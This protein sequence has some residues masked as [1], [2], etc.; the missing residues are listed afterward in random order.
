MDPENTNEDANPL[1]DMFVFDKDEQEEEENDYSD[2]DGMNDDAASAEE[3]EGE[4]AAE[5]EEGEG[6]ADGED[7]KDTDG[8]FSEES[9]EAAADANKIDLEDL[10]KKLNTD[11]KTEEELKNFMKGKEAEET[12]D[13]DTLAL[14]SAKSD[15]DYYVPLLS[16]SNEDLMTRQYES[17]AVQQKKDLN[18]EDV[19]FEIEEKV[20]KLLDSN[21][22]DLYATNLRKEIQSK[23]VDPANAIQSSITARKEQE[24]L[25]FAKTEKEALQNAFAKVYNNQNFFGVKISKEDIAQ[26]Y[27]KVQSGEFMKELQSDKEAV[28]ELALFRRFK[29]TIFGKATGM[30]YEDGVKAMLDEFKNNVDQKPIPGTSGKRG[31]SAGKFGSQNQLI[32]DI[33]S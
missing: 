10:N 14:E 4:E 21:T 2:F 6:E 7:K 9:E 1:D 20:Q 15:L 3:E 31:A 22:L 33:T 19:Q 27:K 11:F 32:A 18:D 5:G 13:K 17:M 12:A 30:K 28:A 29:E 16:L 26:E 8:L 24:A 23:K 25:D